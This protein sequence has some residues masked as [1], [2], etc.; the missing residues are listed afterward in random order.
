[1]KPSREAIPMTTARIDLAV[2]WAR[3]EEAKALGARW[4]PSQRTWY[5]P[6]GTDLRGFDRRWLPK[7]CEFDADS[8]SSTTSQEA[9]AEDEEGISLSELLTQVKRVIEQGLP[10]A[11][12]VR[13]EISE[14]ARQ[15][16]PPLPDAGRTGRAG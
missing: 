3:K 12:W 7:G 8:G 14:S 6:A 11:V 1:M 9:D 16:G 2:P 15:E 4:D 5:A 13:A 10:D